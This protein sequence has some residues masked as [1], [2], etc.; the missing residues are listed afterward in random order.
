ME[1]KIQ[2]KHVII[3]ANRTIMDK[4]FR[5]KGHQ[6]RPRSRTLTS[7]HEAILEDVCAPTEIV[8]KRTR[9]NTD[10]SKVLYFY[11]KNI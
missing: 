10:G 5:R 1:K 4:N 8:G 7:V 11:Y 3:V 2:K 9:I 6:T